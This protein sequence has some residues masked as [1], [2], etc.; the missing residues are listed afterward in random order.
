MRGLD[1]L[2]RYTA[3][4]N[5]SGEKIAGGYQEDITTLLSEDEQK[6]ELYHAGRRWISRNNLIHKI[7]KAK[8]SLTEYEKLKRITFPLD[9]KSILLVS[10]EITSDDHKIIKDILNLVSKIDNT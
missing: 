8:Y 5:R 2:I 3:V 7:G 1:P 10:T 6:M 4:I 9:E